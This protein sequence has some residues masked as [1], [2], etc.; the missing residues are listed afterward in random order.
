MSLRCQSRSRCSRQATVVVNR[1]A[2]E[3]PTLVTV[4]QSFAGIIWI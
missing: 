3:H 4:W 2:P 1:Q